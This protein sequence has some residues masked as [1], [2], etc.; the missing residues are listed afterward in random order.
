MSRKQIPAVKFDLSNKKRFLRI[1]F[2]SLFVL[3][4]FQTSFLG[5][6]RFLNTYQSEDLNSSI[7]SYQLAG[8]IIS[9]NP[10]SS[11]AV[12]KNENSGDFQILKVGE[13]FSD[14]ILIQIFKNHIVF[15]RGGK[16]FRL[17]MGNQKPR[18]IPVIPDEMTEQ[19]RPA[20]REKTESPFLNEDEIKPKEFSRSELEKR[21]K[22][23]L[24]VLL[25]EARITPNLVEGKISGLRITRLPEKSILS[26]LGIQRNDII[27]EVNGVRI[28]SLDTMVSLYT[29]F[30]NENRFTILLERNGLM[31]RLQYTLK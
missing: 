30:W 25:S 13:S 12:L 27:K 11:L 3:I 14:M 31:I 21:F 22:E 19:R 16:A 10:K 18:G 29:E 15:E 1:C 4:V 23:E 8:V 28:N 17:F 9:K 7:F 2:I 6:S 20:L 26:E 24:P 5:G